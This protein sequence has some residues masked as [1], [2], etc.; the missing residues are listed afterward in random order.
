MNE[1]RPRILVVDDKTQNRLLITEY[2]EPL[3][4]L[5]EEAASGKECL[6]LLK[7]R[8]YSLVILD[9]QM[10]GLSGFQVLEQMRSEKA[11]ETIPVVFISAVFNSEEYILKGIEK[12]AID[13]MAK[14][15]N[16][17]ILQNKVNNFL[18][19]YE[20][21]KALD[22]LVKTLEEMNKRLEDS[23]KKFK[24]ITQS[25]NDAIIVLDQN[26]FIRFWN[27]AANHIFGYSRYEILS[28]NFSDN[29]ISQVSQE[30]FKGLIKTLLNSSDNTYSNTIRLI[31]RNRNFQ[32]FPIELSLAYFM[33]TKKEINLTLVI[34]DITR[35]VLME[36]EALKAKEL[37]EAN[38]VM[39]EFMDSVSHELRTPM[40]AILGISNMLLNYNSGNLLTD[41]R[42]GLEIINQSGTRLLEMIN[43]VLDISRLEENKMA[44][45]Y[46][47]FDLDKFLA[48]LHSIIISLIGKKNIK[49]HI[50]KSINTPRVIYSDQKKLN[51]I[52]TNLLGNSAKFTEEGR[53][54]LYIHLIQ[55][56]LYFEVSDTGIGIAEEHL[57]E[58]FD[59]FRQIDNSAT[60]VYQGTG[61]GLN[62]CKKL[63]ELLSGEIRAESTL[64]E[65]T[66]IKFYL[67]NHRQEE[68]SLSTLE[69]QAESN[70]VNFLIDPDHIYNRLVVII[71]ENKESC[72][73][74]TNLFKNRN[75]NLITCTSS[76]NAIQI[77]TKYIP[78]I[79][80][81]K[82]EMPKIHGMSII[83]SISRNSALKHM[84][85]IAVT[86]A[87]EF[88]IKN[89]HNPVIIMQ[90]PVSEE[91]INN[92]IRE[93]QNTEATRMK[94]KR[95]VL[96]ERENHLKNYLNTEDECY[97]NEN[98]LQCKLLLARRSVS[99]LI[100]DDIDI[101]GEN[102]KLVKW[103]QTNAT[104]SP[105]KL[106]IVSGKPFKYILEEIVKAP[107]ISYLPINSVRSC[108]SLDV[109]LVSL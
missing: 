38:R 106:V 42:E 14:P 53:I 89:V 18:K 25:A 47:H 1:N 39:K 12:G 63:I 83:K 44:V 96:F 36:S 4:V 24:R 20:K 8:E 21:Q 56:K 100:F 108:N 60:K 94:V 3:N 15:I 5:I 80:L 40:N 54:D 84:S 55:D 99:T 23:E 67:P 31:G 29:C 68:N 16:V 97:Q 92:A 72:Y 102:F 52:L 79:L 58:I 65:G 87:G 32:E 46:D 9:V 107:G 75:F 57:E 82:M 26:Y 77:I 45:S 101:S 37:R 10:P 66:T 64:G 11:L 69:E 73:W 7:K 78:D 98:F 50:H 74:Y 70:E 91:A 49:F 71:E 86:H 95:I 17:N 48:P 19:L 28:E 6:E 85:I 105:E 59:K 30:E 104:F 103:L 109:A 76:E 35:R 34:R 27:K 2:L 90:E 41:Q 13:F 33:N 88:S 51:Q 62:I 81:I 93:V 22:D 43:D 61:L